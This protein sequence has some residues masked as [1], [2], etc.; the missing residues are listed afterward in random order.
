MSFGK[1]V[2]YQRRVRRAESERLTSTKMKASQD[3]GEGTSIAN[4]A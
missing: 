4:T 1:I 3:V 2:E